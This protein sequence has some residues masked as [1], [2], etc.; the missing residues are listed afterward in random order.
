MS[1][2]PGKDQTASQGLMGGGEQPE[3]GPGLQVESK[4]TW[5]RE[6]KD[7]WER[8]KLYFGLLGSCPN[9]F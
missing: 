7:S 8:P 6:A 1:G 5:Q 3:G 4:W 2:W 9:Y